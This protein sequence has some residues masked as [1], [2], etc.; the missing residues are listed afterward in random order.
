MLTYLEKAIARRRSDARA[1]IE[2]IQ[3]TSRRMAAVHPP[4][5]NIFQEG[6]RA[7]ITSAPQWLGAA[8]AGIAT[9]NPAVSAALIGATTGSA[10]YGEARAFGLSPDQATGKAAIDA[11]LEVATEYI[12]AHRVIGLYRRGAA[13][14]AKSTA[15]DLAEMVGSE[16]IGENIA[17]F[18]QDMNALAFGLD[19]E[20]ETALARGDL[21]DALRIQAARQGVATVAAT[22]SSGALG[23]PALV[24]GQ[25]A[26]EQRERTRQEKIE[27]K[28]VLDRAAQQ[29]KLRQRD[30]ETFA[31]TVR[32]LA[33]DYGSDH[34][35]IDGAAFEQEGLR[36]AVAEAAPELAEP[37]EAAR[38]TGG[39]V[40]IGMADYLAKLAP[41]P[42]IAG[43][44]DA[45]VRFE[46]EGETLKELKSHGDAEL[47]E[48]IDTLETKAEAARQERTRYR[49]VV[50][51]IAAQLTAIGTYRPEESRV[52]A[53]TLASWYRRKAEQLGVPLERFIAE[54]PITIS[55]ENPVDGTLLRQDFFRRTQGDDPMNVSWAMFADDEEAVSHYGK[56]A[57]RLS[58][59]E[60]PDGW[61]DA[62][63]EEYENAVRAWAR[64]NPDDLDD[65]KRYGDG[66]IDAD[67]FIEQIVDGANPDDIVE[68]AGIFDNPDWLESFWEHVMAANGWDTVKTYDGAVT[69]DPEK[70][71]PHQ[72][73]ALY[74]ALP[75]HPP[76]HWEHTQDETAAARLWDERAK[77]KAVFWTHLH[78]QELQEALPETAGYSHSVSAYT[79]RHVR[80][81]HGDEAYE[82]ARGQLPV[83]Q[84]DI[85]QIPAII[86]HPDAIR[87]DTRTHHGVHLIAYAKNLDDGVVVYIEEASS[88]KKNLRGISMW[89]YPLTTDVRQVLSHAISPDHYAQ[90]VV[91]AYAEDTTARPSGQADDE[92]FTQGAARGA[93]SPATSTLALLQGADRS[94]FQHE[95]GH[96]FL[97]KQFEL[98]GALLE[99]ESAGTELSAGERQFLGDTETLLQWFEL[100]KEQWDGMSLEER[101]PYHERFAEGFEAY[102]MEGEAPSVALQG[103]F[104]KLK[105]WL[106]EVYKN[107]T[108][109]GV[110]L[111]DEV[112]A[113]YDRLLAGDEEI[114]RVRE[115]RRMMALFASMEEA[116]VEAA[117]FQFYRE[118]WQEA[119]ET[120][121]EE[122]ARRTLRD[123]KYIRNLKD[124]TIR[125]LQKDM[126]DARKEAR[127]EVREE[128]I[129]LPVYR[130]WAALS[131]KRNDPEKIRL[132]ANGIKALGYGDAQV[133]ALRGMTAKRD[134]MSPEL[135]AETFTDEKGEPLFS[136]GDDLIGQLLDAKPLPDAVEDG[137]DALMLARHG[138]LVSR[139]DFEDAAEAAIQ[140]PAR[141]RILTTE[142]N[143]LAKAVGGKRLLASVAARYAERVIGGN[144]GADVNTLR[145]W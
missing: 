22:V 108:A 87:T 142:A 70:I 40:Q 139:E 29:S 109:L 116:G 113:V 86:A 61:V 126:R 79:I 47:R 76:A 101:R 118:G 45:L 19:D 64:E 130:A 7:A 32:A 128:L 23:T 69:F 9:G 56:N 8:A 37:I 14:A 103:V 51:D 48:E 26:Q 66:F 20:L 84:Q 137:A 85:E 35:Y 58:D 55:G 104:R 122:L 93:F 27:V 16:V 102:L 30:P 90:N 110:P 21:S 59:E 57:W 91:G 74:Q 89:K 140:N 46:P 115:N 72:G 17:E 42:E 10:A 145:H 63:S 39:S 141:T 65:L 60:T 125:R 80:N 36:D 105:A 15:R 107:I 138:G 11:A 41:H 53:E 44:L 136:S 120:A 62:S 123:L 38:R 18:G 67:S 119:T 100:S 49:D 111:S 106:L 112:R 98:T 43:T 33:D 31:Q 134:G 143:L 81:N 124:K 25:R 54:H 13:K 71:R 24:L 95:L 82:M 5:L 133:Q 2:A 50:K 28:Q 73:E 3:E 131:R 96:F 78:N 77:N 68:S 121:K 12:P 6:I 127:E 129:K 75:E 88:K 117:E 132:D 92:H 94:T 135:F 114:E 52:Q 144:F 99:K 83:T 1:N 97:E 34:L 4:D